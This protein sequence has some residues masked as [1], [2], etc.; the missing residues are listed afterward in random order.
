M[1]QSDDPDFVQIRIRTKTSLHAR[2]EKAADER[3]VSMNSE[4]VDRLERSFEIDR[5]IGGPIVEDRQVLAI[6]KM[7]AAVM[8]DS[9]RH[10][11]FTAT[12][13][14]EGTA[15]WYDNAF[16][17]DQAVLAANVILE[18]F[19]PAGSVD[20][21]RLKDQDDNDLSA[22]FKQLGPGFAR[23]L[24]E[25]VA[26]GASRT[27]DRIERIA[28]LRDELGALRDR[29]LHRAVGGRTSSE[30]VWG[31]KTSKRRRQK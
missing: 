26:R 16:A 9:G 7:I 17:Y 23:G 2:L 8:H 12:R 10:A 27:G 31:G 14:I 18:A 20:A 28:I 5:I 30:E 21:P 6:A 1:A 29:I 4:I 15:R 25:E 22:F 3:G 19:R 13:T 11:A 24:L